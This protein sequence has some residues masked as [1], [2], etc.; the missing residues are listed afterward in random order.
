MASYNTYWLLLFFNAHFFSLTVAPSSALS[1]HFLLPY[2]SYLCTAVQP[3]PCFCVNT[4]ICFFLHFHQAFM[5]TYKHI[6]AYVCVPIY[7]Y[8][9]AYVYACVFYLYGIV[10]LSA[11]CFVICHLLLKILRST[12]KT[13]VFS[14]S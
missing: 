7:T 6:C 2:P 3:V 13:L 9:Y 4:I 11:T 10:L 14:F 8:I 5:L 12:G 1:P